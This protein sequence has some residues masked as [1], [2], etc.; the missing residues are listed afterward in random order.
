MFT[1]EGSQF[2]ADFL[3]TVVFDVYYLRDFFS[4]FV[5]VLV[6]Y[7]LLFTRCIRF[8]H[9]IWSK[10]QISWFFGCHL[11][12]YG[13]GFFHIPFLLGEVKLFCWAESH[14]LFR[15]SLLYLVLSVFIFI[16][17]FGYNF[18]HHFFRYFSEHRNRTM[19]FQFFVALVPWRLLEEAV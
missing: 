14:F 6:P 3:N 4:E 7:L 18:F 15:T 13:W 5:K 1:E 11:F 12:P 2:L 8:N 16:R 17:E 9:P 10:T 19:S